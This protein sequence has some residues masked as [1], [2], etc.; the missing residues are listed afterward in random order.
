[1]SELITRIKL[2]FSQ[3]GD[4]LQAA[5][6]NADPGQAFLTVWDVVLPV[7]CGVL[8][9]IAAGVAILIIVRCLLSLF[10]E[11]TGREIWGCPCFSL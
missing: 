8:R 7:A 3:L 2:V 4:Q 11:K 6:E 5:M 9:V 1:M 10:R